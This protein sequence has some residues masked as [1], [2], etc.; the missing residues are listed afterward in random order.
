LSNNKN[1]KINKNLSSKKEPGSKQPITATNMYVYLLA[2]AS[3]LILGLVIL[4]FSR[5]KFLFNQ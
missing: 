1:R 2:G 4:I 3:L 5:K